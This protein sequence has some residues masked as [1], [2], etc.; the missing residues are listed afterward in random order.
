MRSITEERCIRFRGLV[1]TIGFDLRCKKISLP[2][3]FGP[4]KAG[5]L[6]AVVGPSCV[7]GTLAVQNAT[8]SVVS[9]AGGVNIA[10]AFT[11]FVEEPRGESSPGET[12]A[13]EERFSRLLALLG[14]LRLL[15]VVAD[16]GLDGICVM[17]TVS[18]PAR[19]RVSLTTVLAEDGIGS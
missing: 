16:S 5:F 9:Y 7:K 18:V 11:G 15:G 4:G 6:Q 3:R 14:L 12:A 8:K 1:G 10:D 17:V 19:R 13:A 2:D